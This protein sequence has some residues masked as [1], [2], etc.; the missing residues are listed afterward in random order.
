[1][2]YYLKTNN[3]S[4]LK[5]SRKPQYEIRRCNKVE[6]IKLICES[7]KV[8]NI[9]L[10]QNASHRMEQASREQA[11]NA[12]FYLDKQNWPLDTSMTRIRHE[13]LSINFNAERCIET[14]C[15]IINLMSV[16]NNFVDKLNRSDVLSNNDWFAVLGS[17][18]RWN[19]SIAENFGYIGECIFMV[20]IVDGVTCPKCGKH[21]MSDDFDTHQVDLQCL[22]DGGRAKMQAQDWVRLG[23][24]DD[25]TAIRLASMPVELVPEHFGVWTPKWVSDIV[26]AYRNNTEESSGGFADLTLAEFLKKTRPDDK[27]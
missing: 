27:K 7:T 25:I 18:T 15:A 1:M 12:I 14:E 20:Q 2:Y 5:I 16:N 17:T 21:E 13:T 6:L 8:F 24:T 4:K 10:S 3:K 11:S 23:S 9:I 22:I 19:V 26:S